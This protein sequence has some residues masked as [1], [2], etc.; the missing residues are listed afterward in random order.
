MNRTRKTSL[1]ILAAVL[2]IGIS[3]LI[4]SHWNEVLQERA[5]QAELYE[6][7]TSYLSETYGGE[8]EVIDSSFQHYDYGITAG[9]YMYHFVLKDGNGE[10]CKADYYGKS[11]LDESTVCDITFERKG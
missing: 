6:C 2:V 1:I 4:V 11:P 9:I 3:Y 10:Q 7:V 8:Y 5:E